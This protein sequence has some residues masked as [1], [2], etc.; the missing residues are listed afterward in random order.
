MQTMDAHV[1]RKLVKF[2]SENPGVTWGQI[3]QQIPELAG[4][5]GLQ[6]FAANGYPADQGFLVRIENGRVYLGAAA[7]LVQ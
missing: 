3:E 5:P 1:A 4:K 7:D 2:V 6:D